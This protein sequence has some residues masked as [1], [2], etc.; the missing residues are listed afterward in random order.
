[1]KRPTVSITQGS[2]SDA[3][4][5]KLGDVFFINSN[6]KAYN[7]NELSGLMPLVSMI[8]SIRQPDKRVWL[9][10]ACVDSTQYTISRTNNNK[11]S[12]LGRKEVT[13][14]IN[15]VKDI[16]LTKKF[17]TKVLG[18]NI[19]GAVIS[20]S[21]KFMSQM[22][23]VKVN[24]RMPDISKWPVKSI[25]VWA[26]CQQGLSGQE[27]QRIVEKYGEDVPDK[28]IELIILSSVVKR[29]HLEKEQESTELISTE[30]ASIVQKLQNMRIWYSH[31]TRF[32]KVH[33]DEVVGGS[34]KF[35]KRINP[36]DLAYY[37]VLVMND[38]PSYILV[39]PDEHSDTG[40]NFTFVNG[41]ELY[42]RML[43]FNIDNFRWALEQIENQLRS[44]A[45]SL[46]IPTVEA[47]SYDLSTTTV[48]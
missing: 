47:T 43:V 14:N 30:I 32:I 44:G 23:I 42:S 33:L 31:N 37:S 25:N 7:N 2:A 28:F 39:K 9:F 48:S 24:T 45:G 8:I 22:D 20:T 5:A 15:D 13:F 3:I 35:K 34:I 36:G 12:L 38:L 19:Y 11:I 6:I 29:Q 26:R 21:E 46:H 40:V 18:I 4:E 10:A 41:R 16:L 1:M 17:P 27:L